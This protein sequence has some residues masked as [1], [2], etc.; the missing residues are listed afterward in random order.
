MSKHPAL[1][2]AELRRDQLDALADDPSFM[3]Q[4]EEEL[5]DLNEVLSGAKEPSIAYL[6]LEFGLTAT[7]PLYAGGLGVL[8][9]DH[10]KAASDRGLPL[11]G[12]GLFY[13]HGIFQQIIED[14]QQKEHYR[15]AGPE[16]YG[17]S[18][19]G[20]VVRVPLPGRD[21]AARVWRLD[22]GRIPLILL[23]TYVSSNSETDREVADR[24]YIGFTNERVN[25]EMILGIGG[26]RALA[27]LGYSIDAYHLNEGHAGFI[28]LELIDRVIEEGNLVAAMAHNRPHILFTTHTPVPA[29]IDRF[30][31][32]ALT[33]F[34]EPWT[35]RW[36]IDFGDLW[37]V[38]Q[39]S[40]NHEKFNMAG[41]C[42]NTAGAANGVSELHGEVSRRLFAGVGIGDEI[43]HVTNGVHARTWTAPH[44]QDLFDEVLGEG[45]DSGDAGA[46][47]RVDAI[48]LDR[49]GEERVRSAAL[50]SH[51]VH[52]RVGGSL[53]PEALT[54]GFARRFVPYKR[55]TLFMRDLERLTN[56]LSD[57][58][59]PIQFVFAGKAHPNDQY[60]KGIVSEL[61]AFANSPAS[62][63]R[64]L[65]IPDYDM[66]VGHAMVK[67]SDIWMNNPVRPREASGTSGEKVALNGGLNFSVL[68]GWWAEM[69]DGKNGWE[70]RSSEHGDS[71]QR[72]QEEAGWLL[73]TLDS[74]IA[75]YFD[76]R[77]GFQRRILHAWASLGPRV[78]AARMLREYDERYYRPALSRT[79][80]S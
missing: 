15:F 80:M 27:A 64:V 4:V 5:A 31:R 16:D 29:G 41:F 47:Q 25:Q 7:V 19:T 78:T 73:D 44:I 68:D 45:W 55:A 66:D 36:G 62:R 30:D 42:L 11:V 39:D 32:S 71:E 37:S 40:E 24:L 12:V 13:R 22:V 63:G 58:D 8:A 51:L 6:S 48:D 43:G 2:V 50:L 75:E 57:E 17:A 72:D 60:G 67:G 76:D 14:N 69:Y 18:D 52:S 23:D 70:I 61:V 65:F 46:W 9:G 28:N 34:L 49:V 53:D 74:I 20:I 77:E 54:I 10:V 33:P 59:R 1:A 38:G 26:A 3:S 56:L 21:V 35:H 79:S